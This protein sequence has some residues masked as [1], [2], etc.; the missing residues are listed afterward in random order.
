[1][2]GEAHWYSVSGNKQKK[3]QKINNADDIDTIH[4][5]LPERSL[6]AEIEKIIREKALYFSLISLDEEDG[7]NIEMI[8]NVKVCSYEDLILIKEQIFKRYPGASFRFY[9]SPS[10]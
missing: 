3:R 7:Q 8:F 10:I 5:T 1:M 4:I 9:N 2:A 6:I